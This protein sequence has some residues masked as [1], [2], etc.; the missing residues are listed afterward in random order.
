MSDGLYRHLIGWTDDYPIG[1]VKKVRLH[2]RDF[3]LFRASDGSYG[4]LDAFCPH[5]G[6][7]LSVLGTVCGNKCGTHTRIR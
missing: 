4:L 6:A 7:D 1:T 2:S 5:M 3:V